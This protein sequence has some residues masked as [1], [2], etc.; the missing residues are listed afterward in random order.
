MGYII[1]GKYYKGTPDMAKLASRQQSTYKQ[2]EQNRQRHDFAKEI[3]QPW[4]GGKPNEDF[5]GAYPEE[6]KDYG[7]LPKDEDLK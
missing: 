1:D 5:I 7:F 6:S 3:L 4:K 2:H